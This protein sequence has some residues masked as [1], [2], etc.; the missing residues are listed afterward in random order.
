[1]SFLFR[2]RADTISRT[3]SFS[4]VDEERP[5][6]YQLAA[7]QGIGRRKEQQDSFAYVNEN[8]V[9]KCKREGLFAIVADGMG[10]LADGKQVSELVIDCMLRSF[11]ELDYEGDFTEQLKAAAVQANN[12]AFQE[13]NSRGGSTLVACLLYN[14]KLWYVNVGDSALFLL[15]NGS[16]SQINVEQ[17]SLTSDYRHLVH[18]G[19]MNPEDARSNPE[20]AA[21]SHYMGMYD[22][23]EVDAFLR[24]LPLKN[25]DALL[26]CSDGISGFL[27]DDQIKQCMLSGS[28]RDVCSKLEEEV[29]RRAAKNQDNYTAVVIQCKS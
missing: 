8:D 1:M 16:L 3:T 29:Y 2:R 5:I 17:N 10:G 24:P 13:Y 20:K 21:L 28:P 25:G 4:P 26:I 19:E 23:D 9:V 15:R 6:T 14:G 7:L 22:L 11:S 18:I 27:R 12:R